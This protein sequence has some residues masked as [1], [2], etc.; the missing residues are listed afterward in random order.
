MLSEYFATYF[1]YLFIY[2]I[3]ENFNENFQNRALKSSKISWIFFSLKISFHI[4]T[5]TLNDLEG[6]FCCLKPS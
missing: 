2:A 6:H 4:L 5:V 1:I 3:V